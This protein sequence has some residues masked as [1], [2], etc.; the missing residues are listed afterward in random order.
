MVPVTSLWAPILVSAVI[1]FVASA[2]V[3]MVLPHHRNDFDTVP[4]E[5]DVQEAL[6]RFNIPPGDY[7]L[8]CAR[9]AAAMKDPKFI[10]RR[11][12]GPVLLMTVMPS[13]EMGMGTQLA[14]WF[15]NSIVIGIFAA[16]VAGRAVPP[17]GDYL[18]VFRFAGTTAFLAYAYALMHDSIWFRRR[19]ST[20]A[21]YLVDGLVYGLLTAGTFGWLW[22]R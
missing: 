13:G 7:L 16:Y 3:H 21:R 11:K 18:Q 6:R 12:K 2:I 4:K 19:W 5:D 17:G 15:V 22:P 10:E 9:T 20:T 1:V 14:L 8:P